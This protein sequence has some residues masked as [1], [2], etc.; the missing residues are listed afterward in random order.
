MIVAHINHGI[1]QEAIED[2]NFV[3]K[4]CNENDIP[5]FIKKAD[6]RQLA[7][8][9]NKGQEEMGR[10]VRYEFFDEVAKKTESNKI[11][12]AHNSNDNAETIIMNI[13][14]GTGIDGLKGIEVIREG[15][16][17][18]P[19]IEIQREEIEEYCEKSNLNPRIDK[20]NNEN[21]YT[22]NKIR[23]ICIPYIKKEFNPNIIANMNRIGEIAREEISLIDELV[24]N[25][26]DNVVIDQDDKQ[27]IFSLEEFNKLHL[28]I[29]K[30]LI[31]YTINKVCGTT[32]DIQ[33]IH[34]E[35]II[36]MLQNNIG[37][38]YLSPK[39]YI[40]ISLKCK[41]IYFNSQT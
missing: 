41:K 32:R 29:K 17:I 10:F 33:K 36:K 5:I 34:I 25:A 40:K 6:I 27:I 38:K 39:K 16:I 21:D 26:F 9:K 12:I 24:K 18:R 14:R 13:L 20:T 37:N 19:L 31:L 8:E 35:D 15:R 30:K 11:A 3:K 4:Y 2:E 23:N 28:V 7:K 1:R 22:R